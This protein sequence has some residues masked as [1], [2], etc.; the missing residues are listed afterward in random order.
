MRAARLHGPRDVRIGDVPEPVPAEG[1]VLIRVRAVSIC[2][3]DCRMY[4][5][6][7]AGGVIPDHPMIQGHEFAG[8][9]IE[10]GRQIKNFKAG[11]RVAIDP[12]FWCGRCAACAIGHFPA[13][14]S[15]KL[16]G[17]DT[18]GG[19]GEYVAA[20]KH[21]LYKLP[22]GI[23][24]RHGAL[25]ELF[26]IGFHACNRSGIQEGDTAAI[27]GGGKVGQAIL[28][29]V[30]NRTSG[31]IFI[32]DILDERLHIA[33]QVKPDVVLI[34]SRI[35]DPDE[36]IKKQTSGRGV[37]IAFEAVGH[38]LEIPGR[39]HPFRQCIQS[40]RPAGTICV[41]GLSN[42]AVPFVP[43]EFI[44]KEAKI[45]ASRVTAGEFSEAIQHL[46]QGRL[47]P[48]PLITDELSASC[49]QDA[50]EMLD[51]EPEKHLKVLI[52]PGE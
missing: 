44:F 50:F 19:F 45:I 33:E 6:G 2:A 11:D 29:A 12:V 46:E 21:M 36:I 41:L 34:N 37:D 35:V 30:M 23:P 16:L 18:D 10:C 1:E 52:R 13:C 43:R 38:A 22:D 15:L 40:I 42:K 3:S 47:V 5:D 51:R 39:E 28:Q 32:V 8:T 49:L 9:I 27:F 20:Q 24:D 48:G 31:K 4:W 7:H 14:T 26:S 17:V 25:V